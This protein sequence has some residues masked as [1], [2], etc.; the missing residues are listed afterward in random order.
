MKQVIYKFKE[1]KEKIKNL[2]KFL[3]GDDKKIVFTNGCFDLLHV[4][5]LRYLKKAKD[6]GDVL[7][8][9]INS[10]QSVKKNKGK[11]RPIIQEK[12]RSEL[13]SGL[14]PVDFV[15]VFEEKTP[16]S[17]IQEISPDYLVKGGDWKVEDIVGSDHVISTGGEVKS[18]IFEKGFS[19]TNIINKILNEGELQ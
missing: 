9:G 16:L 8:T 12:D 10:D 3:K 6:L 11:S 18:I 17:L 13:L 4:G 5:H 7:I 14:K 15:I 19:S 1:E 2:I